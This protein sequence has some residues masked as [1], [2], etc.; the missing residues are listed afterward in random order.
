MNV[1]EYRLKTDRLNRMASVDYHACVGA[2][3]LTRWAKGAE[4]AIYGAEGEYCPR[5]KS[6]DGAARDRACAK[7]RPRIVDAKAKIM[8]EE[9]PAA[10]LRATADALAAMVRELLDCRTGDGLMDPASELFQKG[11]RVLAAAKKVLK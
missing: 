5:M 9:N 3:E 2:A 8:A 7:L 4:F 1:K 11:D 10:A 6:E